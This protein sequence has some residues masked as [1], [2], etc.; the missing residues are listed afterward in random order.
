MKWFLVGFA[1]LSALLIGAC[2]CDPAKPAPEPTRA[3]WSSELAA[4]AET[5]DTIDI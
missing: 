1:V 3:G 4:P 5:Y 2:A